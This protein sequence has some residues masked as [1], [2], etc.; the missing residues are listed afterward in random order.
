MQI[1][2]IT[3]IIF[4]NHNQY[5][6][7]G[8]VVDL[9]SKMSGIK[10]FFLDTYT[11]IRTRIDNV[12]HSGTGSRDST[13]N[14]TKKQS[15]T[16]IRLLSVLKRSNPLSVQ[17]QPAVKSG[18]ENAHR[19][20]HILTT[21]Q[22]AATHGR[23]IETHV[24]YTL[25]GY[26]LTLHRLRS[27][28]VLDTTD[29]QS[30]KRIILLH[31]GLLGSSADWILLGPKKALP[32]IL[33][34]E[35][36]DVWMANA[37]GNY[38]SRAHVSLNLNSDEYWNFSWQEIGERDLPAILDYIRKTNNSTEPIDYIGHSM[39]ATALLVL[40][41]VEHNYN[42]YIRIAFLLAP[43]AFMAHTRG[44]M[45]M[46]A[47]MEATWLINLLGTREFAP[48]RSTHVPANYADLISKLC[49]DLDIFCHNPLFFL[50]GS[51]LQEGTR[52]VEST[53][54]LQEYIP[55]GGSSKTIIHYLMLIASKKFH[56]YK[57]P[58]WQFKLKYISTP[59]LILSSNDDLISNATDNQMLYL[60]ILNPLGHIIIKDQNF[61]HTEFAWGFNADL[62]IY[63][64]I[65]DLI[66]LGPDV[67]TM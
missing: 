42:R 1:L 26:I 17:S 2:L 41:S 62:L 11:A 27:N 29:P 23:I 58:D 40:L 55:A 50:A 7:C 35:G 51:P 24:T 12:F 5:V 20:A 25:D 39:G 46:M 57:R 30:K 43:L 44:P 33:S 66:E 10:D 47:T 16:N 37:R 38:Y 64:K 36:H 61:S 52:T 22:L 9:I 4:M 49:N 45:E 60:S 18:E 67:I 59:M 14:N 28:K 53:D 34:D 65:R 48:N 6:K 56:H 8:S 13:S 63:Y 3:I 19:P 54:Q 32:Y 31:H 21:P 15:S